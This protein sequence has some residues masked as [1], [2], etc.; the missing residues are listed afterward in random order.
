MNERITP[1]Y[2]TSS[3]LL[4]E[5]L[6]RNANDTNMLD[7]PM[8]KPHWTK[9]LRE[10]NRK[11]KAALDY[12]RFQMRV[13]VQSRFD[14]YQ[15][16]KASETTMAYRKAVTEI[17]NRVNSAICVSQEILD[18]ETQWDVETSSFIN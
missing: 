4:A 5:Q 16:A 3:P 14:K 15:H 13:T 6:E 18:D 2:Q 8:P 9:E 10:E 12:L 11:L 7:L 1:R 17:D